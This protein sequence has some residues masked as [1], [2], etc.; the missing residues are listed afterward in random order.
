MVGGD[1]ELDIGFSGEDH[2]SDPVP[3]KAVQEFLQSPSGFLKAARTDVLS[4]HAIG[5][6][7]ADHQ[8]EAL[9]FGLL[10]F[11]P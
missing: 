11:G 8:V 7:E 2:H 9:G 4:V 10:L 1:R 5:K 6:V 3:V